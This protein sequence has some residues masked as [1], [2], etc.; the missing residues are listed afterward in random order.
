MNINDIK[1]GDILLFSPEK[2][3]FISWAITFLTGAPVSHAAMFY[4][5]E[6]QLI[7]EETPPQVKVSL[8][9][10]RF[11]D[12]EIYVR[13]LNV[14]EDLPLSPV[15]KKATGYL[16]DTEPY[17]KSGLYMV[18]LLLIYKKFTPNT[19]VKKVMVKI[20][21]KITASIIK[22]IHEHQNP[23]K[24]PMVCS[25]FV[26]QCYSDAGD[27]YK[28]KIE[29]GILL[30][31]AAMQDGSFNVLDQVMETVKSGERTNL[32]T[33]LASTFKIQDEPSFSDEELCRELK[34][35]FEL[36]SGE[37][38]SDITDE[39]IEAVSQFSKA[40]YLYSSGGT[41]LQNILPDDSTEILQ[42][43]KDNENMYVFPG[44]LLNHC[45]NLKD[46]GTIK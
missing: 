15:I 46:I 13:R 39:L 35:A 1:T 11:K 21:K 10:E 16:N 45:E 31:N 17:D 36:T 40:H 23:E 29:N 33:L 4:N 22:Y 7:I 26:A 38:T 6:N 20:L 27:K 28:L 42:T 14:K 32:Q 8:A 34:E 9:V 12:R 2:G 43:L 37:I 44:D 30:R 19:S 3:S 18:G 25:Q 41:Q 24:S 5:E